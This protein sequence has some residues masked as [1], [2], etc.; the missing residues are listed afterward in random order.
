ML[1]IAF[2]LLLNHLPLWLLLLPLV[3]VV[4][5]RM[6]R[7]SGDRAVQHTMFVNLATSVLLTVWLAAS[8]E[9]LKPAH[10]ARSLL[11]PLERFQF[12]SSLAWLGDVRLAPMEQLLPNGER[13]QVEAVLRWGPDIRWEVGVDGLSLV[14]VVLSTLSLIVAV[15]SHCRK[16]ARHAGAW[17]WLH[18]SLTGTFLALDVVLFVICWVSAQLAV[19]WLLAQDG[20]ATRRSVVPLWAKANLLGGWFA[21]LGLGGL[22]LTFAWLRQSPNRPQSP[23]VFSIPELIAGIG[24]WTTAGDSLY[25]WAHTSSW[26]FF[27]LVIGFTWPMLLAP[28][29]ASFA[30]TAA[31]APASLNLVLTGALAKVGLYGWLRFIVPV[32]PDELRQHGNWMAS[33]VSFST[34]LAVGLAFGQRDWRRRI[35]LATGCSLGLSLLGIV[36]FTLEGIVGAVFRLVSHGLTV[37]LLWFLLGEN[38]PCPDLGKTERL[39]GR[40]DVSCPA[41]RRE[42]AFRAALFAWIGFPGFS[43][44]VAEFLSPLGLLQHEFNLAILS[45]I[46]SGL[47]AWMWV[48]AD[49][50][51]PTWSAAPWTAREWLVIG[52]LLGMNVI[53]GVAPQL[54][55]SRIEPGMLSMFPVD[56][57]RPHSPT[58]Q[59]LRP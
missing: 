29:H 56:D 58:G 16:T 40:S 59:E 3:G 11:G 37:A 5:V 38:E 31:S 51:Q 20:D 8:Y 17:L 57:F 27:L 26:W 12:R 47:L 7:T 44:F 30:G 4:S 13:R 22:V 45:L 46:T 52:T 6:A 9:P 49:R 24:H 18:A 28:F 55:V 32:F 33:A 10:D 41:R 21:V 23:L 19:A 54:L 39:P 36:T 43:G 15:V 1:E 34:L 14:F 48:R 35:S 53:L 2:R 25:L 42:W 50:D